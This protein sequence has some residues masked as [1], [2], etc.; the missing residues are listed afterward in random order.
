LNTAYWTIGLKGPNGDLVPGAAGAYNLNNQYADYIT[1]E[2]VIVKDGTLRLISQKQDIQGSDPQAPFKYTSGWIQSM[3][4][5]KFTYGYIEARIKFPLGTQVWAAF[6]LL[7]ERRLWGAEFDIAEYW[8]TPQGKESGSGMLGQHLHTGD[9][10]G[11]WLSTWKDMCHD[12]HKGSTDCDATQ[13]HTY[14]LR[15]REDGFDYYIDDV[16]THSTPASQVKGTYPSDDMYIILNN[17][18]F[19]DTPGRVIDPSQTPWPTEAEFDYVKIWK[20][21]NSSGAGLIGN[22]VKIGLQTNATIDLTQIH[23]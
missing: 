16:I 12:P 20:E 18:V 6:W 13:W 21:A 7:E 9:S 5:V 14:G 1:S 17:G 2:N 11:Y 22:D 10:P 15:W 4:K 23:V 19:A 8:G 3:H